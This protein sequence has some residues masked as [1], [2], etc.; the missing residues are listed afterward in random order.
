VVSYFI[1]NYS[2]SS[3]N[4]STKCKPNKITHISANKEYSITFGRTYKQGFFR[5][6]YLLSYTSHYESNKGPNCAA[7]STSSH[8]FANLSNTGT[9]Y[10]SYL[11]NRISDSR[12]DILR[13]DLV[14]DNFAY[15]AYCSTVSWAN[16]ISF[17]ITYDRPY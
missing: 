15:G 11:N 7:L 6:P 5:L 12:T 16:C 13:H 14:T 8:Y 2:N 4:A 1:A 10:R 3:A 9:F 17:K